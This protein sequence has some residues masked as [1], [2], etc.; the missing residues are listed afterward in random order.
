MV[1]VDVM[2]LAEIEK[3]VE[4]LDPSEFA[5]FT[6]WLDALAEARWDERFAADVRAGK[7]DALGKKAI[8]DFE[9]GRCTEL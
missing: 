5:K 7:L 8:G 3:A 4:R 9:A 1:T 6:R 2:S